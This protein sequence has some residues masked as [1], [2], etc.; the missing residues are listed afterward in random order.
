MSKLVKIAK[1]AA[2][3]EARGF[4]VYRSTRHIEI[5]APEHTGP[6]QDY[7]NGSLYSHADFI[8]DDRPGIGYGF[9]SLFYGPWHHGHAHMDDF[10][11][12]KLRNHPLMEGADFS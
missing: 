8:V 12:T 2:I 3:A 10:G 9:N 11:F 7:H 6:D 4:R 5:F 1:I